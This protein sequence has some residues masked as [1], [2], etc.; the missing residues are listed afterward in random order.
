MTP[1]RGPGG[2]L[3][4]LRASTAGGGACH[5][6]EGMCAPAGRWP[7]T[8][9]PPGSPAEQGPQPCVRRSTF[10]LGNQ[11]PQGW[12][13]GMGPLGGDCPRAP[14]GMGECNSSSCLL[15]V[16][17]WGSRNKCHKPGGNSFSHGSGG[18]SLKSRNGQ[19]CTPLRAQG[20]GP[21]HL[22]QLSG[23]PASWAWGC[24]PPVLP[25]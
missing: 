16:V 14:A 8:T 21:S 17:S 13:D 25:P 22:P 5:G 4:E 1:N 6:L 20:K 9:S 19:G 15:V 7:R 23:L 3:Q 11:D 10:A 12:A 18:S 24:L 2:H